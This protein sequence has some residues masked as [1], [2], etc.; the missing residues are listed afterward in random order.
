MGYWNQLETYISRH[1]E[2]GFSHGICPECAEAMYPGH[3]ARRAQ[4]KDPPQG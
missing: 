1:S 2:V 3:A 4:K